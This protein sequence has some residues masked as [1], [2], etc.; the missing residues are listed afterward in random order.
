M[1]GM[2]KMAEDKRY[3]GIDVGGT[4][5]KT[6]IVSG[7][8]Q[9]L[10][11]REIETNPGEGGSVLDTIARGIRE[12]AA[13]DRSDTSEYE[14]IA[15]AA[16]GSIDTKNGRVA[17]N[18]GNVPNWSGTDVRS[19]LNKEFGLPVSLVNDGN[20]VALAEAWTGAAGGC[21][22]VLCVVVGTGIG[23]GIIS[24]GRLI[25]G[26]I[27]F[28]GE[29][30]H[31]ATHAGGRKCV[32]GGC[33]CFE[34]YAS[35]SALVEEAVKI[36]V[37]WSDGRSLFK[38]AGKGDER[39]LE[40][41]D[42]WVFELACGVASLVHIF[43]PKIVLIGGGVSAQ[44]DLVVKPLGMKV[45]ELIMPDFADGLVIRRAELGNNAGIIGAVKHLMDYPV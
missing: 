17:I 41:I 35:T 3:I 20:A 28:A 23:G 43:N 40:L 44:E 32:C 34:R 22:D 30:G 7:K 9:I 13:E 1:Q 39:A 11:K 8:G 21:D 36:N 14:G 2:Y 37:E 18:G 33:G 38:D 16:P 26:S 25:E 29:I 6:G 42:R 27:G 19:F 4:A 31:F 12:I 10:C 45:D 24:G 15:V 5:I